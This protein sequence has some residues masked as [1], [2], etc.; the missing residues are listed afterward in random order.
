MCRCLYCY[1]E[2][3]PGQVDF[4]PE[5]AKKFF[6]TESA[7]LLPYSRSNMHDLAQKVIRTSTSVT[8]V[9]AKMSLDID[10][11]E[12]KRTGQIHGGRFVGA[13][14]LQAGKFRLSLFAAIGRSDHENGRGRRNQSS[15]ALSC[16]TV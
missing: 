12:K 4:H 1:K 13:L 5:C 9:Q 3:K 8:G 7:P 6:G 14:H 16:Q 10:K 2:L 11:G 15:P